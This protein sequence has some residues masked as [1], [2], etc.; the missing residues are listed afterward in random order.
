LVSSGTK[1]QSIFG[2]SLLRQQNLESSEFELCILPSAIYAGKLG[3]AIANHRLGRG[4]QE[5]RRL[6]GEDGNEEAKF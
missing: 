3:H 5:N 1:L 6:A 2:L 4:N